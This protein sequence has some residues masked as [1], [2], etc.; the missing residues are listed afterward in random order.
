ML[1]L[2][3][4]IGRLMGFKFIKFFHFLARKTVPRPLTVR[5]G[6]AWWSVG[7]RLFAK[8]H[9]KCQ[10][11]L[12][13]DPHANQFERKLTNAGNAKAKIQVLDMKSQVDLCPGSLPA[14]STD[15]T[16]HSERRERSQA[17]LQTLAPQEPLRLESN[18]ITATGG[19]TDV[20]FHPTSTKPL[21]ATVTDRP[22][23]G[24]LSCLWSAWPSLKE[25]PPTS[26]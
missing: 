6:T 23:L 17:E 3:T 22:S 13:S 18:D 25:N 5:E 1:I 11:L 15:T 19:G 14:N 10:S 2:L 8:S 7:T 16:N 12:S 9:A 26:G 4:Y 20:L 21:W 24:T